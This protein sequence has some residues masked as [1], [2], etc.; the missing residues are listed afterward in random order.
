MVSSPMATTTAS[1]AVTNSGWSRSKFRISADL[2]TISTLLDHASAVD[3]FGKSGEPG[4][5]RSD[6]LQIKS[7][8]WQAKTLEIRMIF[9]KRSAQCASAKH[10]D[11]TPAQ[12]DRVWA[13]ADWCPILQKRN[14]ILWAPR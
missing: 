13:Y 1:V 10:I 14:A 12:P 9:Q 7:R 6:T 3:F 5:N 4:G 8:F 2:E 11:A